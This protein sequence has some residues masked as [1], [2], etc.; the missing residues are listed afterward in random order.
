MAKDFDYL[1]AQTRT[2]LDEVSQ[3]D[4]K[5]NEVE[6]EINNGY[7]EV[8]SSVMILN[9]NTASGESIAINLEGDLTSIGRITSEDHRKNISLDIGT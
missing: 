3:A 8:V 1:K 6:R 7:H 9:D 5:D 2:Y 4:W